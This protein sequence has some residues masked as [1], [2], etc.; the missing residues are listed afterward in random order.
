MPSLFNFLYLCLY[1]CFV[2]FNEAKEIELGLD[3]SIDNFVQHK[4]HY[5]AVQNLKHT[6]KTR[7]F[8]N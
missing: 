1:L 7:E 4:F 5:L 8:A 6:I 2:K 3:A